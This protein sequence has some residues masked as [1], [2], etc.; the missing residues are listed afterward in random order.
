MRSRL[1][2]IGCLILLLSGLSNSAS[3]VCN[4]VPAARGEVRGALGSLDR[5]FAGPGDLVEMTVQPALCDGTSTGFVDLDNDGDAAD[6]HVVAVLFQPPGGGPASAA[7]LAEGC[8][9]IDTAGCAADLG[10]GGTATCVDTAAPLPPPFDFPGLVV[11]PPERLQFRFPDTDA[12]VGGASDGRTLAGPATIVV[13]RRDRPLRCDLVATRCADLAGDTSTTGVVACT[14]ELYEP[15]G[16]CRTDP[17]QVATT[18]GNFTALPPAN[19]LEAMIDLPGTTEVRFTT[20][21]A[22]NALVPMDYAGVLVRVDSIPVPQ[23]ARAGTNIEAFSGG[24]AKV[25]LPG[26]GFVGS[27]SPE[28]IPLPPVFTPLQDPTTPSEATLFGSVDAPRGVI[29]IAR[30]GC[31]GGPDEGAT[32]SQDSECTSDQCSTDLFDFSDRYVAGVGPVVLS[33]SPGP[34]SYNASLDDPVPIAALAQGEESFVFPVPEGVDGIDRNGDGDVTDLVVTVRDPASAATL[35]IGPLASKGRAVAQLNQVPFRFP[36][37]VSAGDLVA[38]L[39]PEALQ[40]MQDAPLTQDTNANGD[41]FETTLKA[42]RRTGSTVAELTDPTSPI[43]AD[44][45]LVVDG[46][47]AAF[48]DGQLFFRTAEWVEAVQETVRVN[49]GPGGVEANDETPS[50][51]DPAISDDGRYVAFDSHANNLVSGDSGT[52]SDVFVRDLLLDSTIRVSIASDGTPGNAASVGPDISADGRFVVFGSNATNLVPGDTNGHWDIFLHDRDVDEDGVFDEPGEIGTSRVNLDSFGAEA[53]ANSCPFLLPFFGGEPCGARTPTITG[54]GRFVGFYSEADNLVPDDTNGEIDCFVRD[55]ESG[56]TRRVN[57]STGGGQ[58]NGLCFDTQVSDDGRIAVFTSSAPDLVPDDTNA[59][60]DVFA[61]DLATGETVRLSVNSVGEETSGFTF[62]GE[63]GSYTQSNGLSRDGRFVSIFS[64]ADNLTPEPIFGFEGYLHDRLTGTTTLLTQP[65]TGAATDNGAAPASLSPSGRFGSFVSFS[66][67][68]TTLPDTNSSGDVFLRDQSSGQVKMVSVDSNGVQGVGGSSFLD[69]VS[70]NGRIVVFGSDATNLVPSDGNGERDL[71]VRRADPTDLAAD[72]TGDGALDDLVLRVLD[73][74]TG[75]PSTV[76][77]LCPAAQVS[78]AAGRAAFLRPES[79]GTT[80]NPAC[81]G[82]A[83]SGPELNADGD[84]VPDDEVVHLWDGLAVT[85]L[86]CAASDLALSDTRLAALVSEAHQGDVDRTGDADTDDAVLAVR[87]ATAAGA[88]ADCAGSGWIDTGLAGDALAVVG[89]RVLLAS[90]EADQGDTDLNGD[91]DAEDRV[92]R[93][94]EGTTG[95]PVAL[96]D[97]G[98]GAT[99]PPAVEEFVVGSQLVALRTS[100]AA[101]GD[102]DLNGDGDTA[103]FVLQVVELDTGRVLSSGEAARPCELVACDPRRAYRV[104]AD[105][106]RFLQLESDQGSLGGQVECDGNADGDCDDLLVKLFNAASGETEVIGEV[107]PEAADPTVA[108]NP[109]TA[110]DPLGDVEEGGDAEADVLV[111]AGRCVALEG[112]DCSLDPSLCASGQVCVADGLGGAV[113]ALTQGTC[114]SVNDCA[115]GASCVPDPVVIGVVDTD[116]DQIPEG[117]DNCSRFA[118]TDQADADGDGVGDPC[119]LQTCGNG[120]TELDEA[121]DDGDLISGDGCDANCTVTAC[122]NGIVTG[123]EECDD[124]NLLNGDGCSAT[125]TL[126]FAGAA[127]ALSARTVLVRDKDGDP[128]RRRLVLLSKDA[129][130]VV[131]VAGPGDPTQAGGVLH[132]ENPVTGESDAYALPAAGWRGLG[133]DPVGAKGW[134]Y[135]DPKGNLGPCKVVKLVPGRVLKAVCLGDQM[136]FSL[137]EAQQGELVAS[138]TLGADPPQCMAFPPPTVV[139][140]TSASGGATG[141]FKARDAPAPASCGQ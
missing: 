72:L 129:N 36:G 116:G 103:D 101:Q 86:R 121:C 135:K 6:D 60:S 5:P 15:D 78:V 43:S 66:S 22:G 21:G 69:T 82:P 76:T 59:R 106:V 140:D 73:T 67:N 14:D 130:L 31:I 102:T 125:C 29:R 122:G 23:L 55:L 48:S 47:S 42:Y 1:Y 85:N 12:Q 93:L 117:L 45:G 71:F 120:A 64:I 96:Q 58:A 124:G 52:T 3:A 139:R 61:H 57:V 10:V 19:D 133:R 97:A 24:G 50:G 11:S 84:T 79:A 88:G 110:S 105:T 8:A 100:E 39:E 40:G 17:A 77:D 131:P 99:L 44:A 56:E 18:F 4:V 20:D 128:T 13:T 35:P 98:G 113:C 70:A 87:A 68:M 123:S 54:N 138:L 89:D 112:T 115:D 127:G 94:V 51:S 32:C 28:G 90:S 34:D 137:D 9:G 75:P 30:R 141:L 7:L 91:T 2:L 118:N 53:N 108:Q 33:G 126:S 41:V 80:T 46:Q 38:F 65:L 136:S 107:L 111:S 62:A 119:D 81:T 132:L 92:L 74:S 104:L 37:V 27:Y 63:L 25:D 95:T 114:S 26:D 134:I 83:L 49:L 109:A 16:T